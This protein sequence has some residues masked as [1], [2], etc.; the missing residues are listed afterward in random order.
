MAWVTAP[1]VTCTNRIFRHLVI[2][3][4]NGVATRNKHFHG[5]DIPLLV[6]KQAL[7]QSQRDVRTSKLKNEQLEP[8]EIEFQTIRT[9]EIAVSQTKG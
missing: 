7:L 9:C 5:S 4:A 6:V 8:R 2:F 3:L 1:Q